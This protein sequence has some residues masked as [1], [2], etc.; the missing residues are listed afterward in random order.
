MEAVSIKK[1]S[2]LTSIGI[3]T[4]KIRRSHHH[5][6]FNMGIHI[7]VKDGLYIETGL[8]M[9]PYFSVQAAECVARSV[10]VCCVHV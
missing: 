5:L 9:L 8:R 6:I 3:P 4:L 1:R 7:P 2:R 10:C